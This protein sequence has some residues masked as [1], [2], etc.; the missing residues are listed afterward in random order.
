[1][2]QTTNKPTLDVLRQLYLLHYYYS[3][4]QKHKATQF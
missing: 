1:M 4:Q 3:Q 2:K